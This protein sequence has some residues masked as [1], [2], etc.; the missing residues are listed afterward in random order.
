MRAILEFNLPEDK[1]DYTFASRG[2]DYWRCLW[3]FSEWLWDEI[4]HNDKFGYEPVY[5][6]LHEIMSNNGC[7]LEDVE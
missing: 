4:T 6:M 7:S 2:G 3:D 1:D 5:K